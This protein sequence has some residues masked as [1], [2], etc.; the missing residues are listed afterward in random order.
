MDRGVTEPVSFEQSPHLAVGPLLEVEAL[1]GIAKVNRNVVRPGKAVRG[2]EDVD[3]SRLEEPVDHLKVG[4]DVVG[5]K[6]LEE[7]V[8]KGDV[9]ASIRKIEVIPVVDD[10]FEV[11]RKDFVGGTLVGDVDAVDVLA[12][13][14]RRA[15]ETAIPGGDLDKNGFRAR[16][17]KVGTK[18][19]QLRFE[20]A[21]GSLS[22]FAAGQPGVVLNPVKQLGIEGL[23]QFGAFLAGG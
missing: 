9:G 16:F 19:A 12:P 4:A 10:E 8:A 11:L 3:S 1:E 6:V 21:A 15:A 17:G 5:M 18:E 7:L 14:R 23:E 22:G 13:L 2:I 20:V